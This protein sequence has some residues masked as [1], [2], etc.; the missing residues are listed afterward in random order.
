MC[1]E[2]KP[3]TEMGRLHEERFSGIGGENESE[4]QGSG[5]GWWRQQ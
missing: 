2:N 1:S 5:D 4:G 3:V